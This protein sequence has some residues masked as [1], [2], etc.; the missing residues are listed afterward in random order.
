MWTM[1]VGSQQMEG[2]RLEMFRAGLRH[3]KPTA[4]S[5]AAKINMCECDTSQPSSVCW[6]LRVRLID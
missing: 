6:A 5:N 3:K 2:L 1:T 4:D